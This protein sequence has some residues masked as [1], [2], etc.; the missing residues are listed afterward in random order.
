MATDAMALAMYTL[1]LELLTLLDGK[2][3]ITRSEL[4]ELVEHSLLNL[5]TH[6]GPEEDEQTVA[7]YESARALLEQLALS[8]SRRGP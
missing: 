3:M 8:I 4:K 2:G 7:S 1:V 6:Q 5:E